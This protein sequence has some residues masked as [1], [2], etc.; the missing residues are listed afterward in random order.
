MES[1]ISGSSHRWVAII[2]LG[3]RKERL[4]AGLVSAHGLHGPGQR[5]CD[6]MTRLAL[7]AAQDGLR[8]PESGSQE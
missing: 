2:L 7:L 4:D 3:F 8:T 5:A 1:L 6:T